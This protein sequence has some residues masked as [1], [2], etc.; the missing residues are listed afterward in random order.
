MRGKVGGLQVELRKLHPNLQDY[1]GCTSHLPNLAQKDISDIPVIKHMQVESGFSEMKLAES[2]YQNH[3]LL[4]TYDA[5]RRVRS[6]FARDQIEAVTIPRDL[7]DSVA[8]ASS[9]YLKSSQVNVATNSERAKNAEVDR[10]NFAVYKKLTSADLKR[11][12]DTSQKEID[13]LQAKLSKAM[14]QK[15]RF[16][17]ESRGQ[18]VLA[19]TTSANVIDQMF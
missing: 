18:S 16:E 7:H 17:K 10:E 3:F 1:V 6:F 11:K 15:E 19:E 2:K 13:D 5:L 14:D 12:I 9:S 4:D 8:T